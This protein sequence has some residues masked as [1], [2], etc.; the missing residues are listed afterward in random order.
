M[1]ESVR[2]F[3]DDEIEEGLRSGAFRKDGVQIRHASEGY[4]VK[5]IKSSE[6]SSNHIP[7]SILQVNNT[8]VYSADL[9]PV[10]KAISE[11]RSVTLFEDLQEKYASV[12]DSLDHYDSYGEGLDVLQAKCQEASVA[13]DNRL[14]RSTSDVTIEKVENEDLDFLITGMS[15]YVKTLF[16]YIVSSY[17]RFG[18]KFSSDKV[19]IG[20]INSFDKIVRT[21]YE[22]LLMPSYW[23]NEKHLMELN[24]SIYSMYFFG[25]GYDISELERVVSEDSRFSS[26]LDVMLL[27]KKS[28]RKDYNLGRHWEHHS[29]KNMGWEITS[30][31]IPRDSKRME[32]IEK[33]F[34][35][36]GDIERLREIRREVVEVKDVSDEYLAAIREQG[37]FGLHRLS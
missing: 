1:A 33:L 26:V 5:V 35:I 12:L 16:L 24:N 37:M 31:N 8:I 6:E 25:S 17:L 36:L 14:Q 3:S 30:K 32:F 9:R 13:F 23:K 2:K 4:V 20:K 21:L 15:A 7:S 19:A 10:L 28:L 22:Q 34:L 29:E 27:F 18:E 11:S